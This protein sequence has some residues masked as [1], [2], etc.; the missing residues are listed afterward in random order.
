[1]LA[2]GAAHAGGLGGLAKTILGGGSV[3]Q[4]GADTCAGKVQ[5]S[6]GDQLALTLARQ[7]AQSAL[8]G[9][10][11]VA[12][13]ATANSDAVTASQKPDFCAKTAKKKNSML[14]TIRDAAKRLATARLGL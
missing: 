5:L 8:P 9:S 3:L 6:P 12:L 2:S 11:F 1:M 13:D 4:R 14:Q 10:D 7:A